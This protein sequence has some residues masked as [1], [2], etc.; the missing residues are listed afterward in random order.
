M[1]ELIDLKTPLFGPVSLF[2]ADGDCIALSGESGSGKSRLLRAIADLDPHDGEVRLDGRSSAQISPARWRRQVQLL[3]ADPQ[4]WAATVGKHFLTPSIDPTVLDLP[5]DVYEWSVERLS[6]GE[7]QR[8]ALLRALD[9]E[10]RVL[11][12]DEPTAN[13]DKDNTARVEKIVSLYRREH[14]AI[15]IWV[16]HDERQRSRVAQAQY[17]LGDG[18]VEP[19]GAASESAA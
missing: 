4:W 18:R 6:S 19:S 5:I 15:V 9:R 16:S 13:L 14:D 1:L 17:R 12:L 3:P 10:P 2:V 7:R 11:L 8:L